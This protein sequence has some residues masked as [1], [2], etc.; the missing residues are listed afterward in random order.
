MAGGSG[1]R[2]W[3]RSRAD[4]PKQL[5]ALAGRRSLLQDAAERMAAVVGWPRVLV[6]T[7]ARHATAVR[8]QLP[9]VATRQRLVEPVGRN[10]APAIALAALHLAERAPTGCMIV[11]P[12]DHV[13][14]DAP[15]F[16]RTI[17][18]ATA[19]AE[20][21]GALVTLGVRPTR[22]ETGY[23][24]IRPG[25]AIRGAGGGVAWVDAFIEKPGLV[26][27]RRLIRSGRA[28]WNSGMFVW[29]VDRILAELERLLPEVV[30]PLAHAMRRGGRAALAR[31]YRRIP[32]VSIDTGVMERAE[33][34]AVVPAGFPWSDVGSWAAVGELWQHRRA[35]AN[36]TRGQVVAL[37]S[38]GCVVDSPRRLVALLGVD[39]LVIV[40]TPDA[41][42]VC[43]RDRAQE[44]R[45][46]VAELRR[47]GLDRYL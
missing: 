17:A 19:V 34:V 27:A 14:G 2:F 31:A 5:L 25:A 15:R 16:R 23:G 26:Q 30:G 22:P 35:G 28:L 41:V 12:S 4:V 43:R 45:R 32:A 39:D 37:D 20:R 1:T 6:V 47:R 46:V 7:G 11:V 38:R 24:Y 9:R 10:T 29:R 13:I 36:A 33:R 8:R 3:P 40:D 18:R 44:V 42:L 21:T